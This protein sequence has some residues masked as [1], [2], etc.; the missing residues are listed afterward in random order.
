MVTK[1]ITPILEACSIVTQSPVIITETIE[2]YPIKAQIW[3]NWF[4]FAYLAFLDVARKQNVTSFAAI[5][6][7]NG[8]DAIGAIHIFGKSL[9]TIVLADINQAALEVSEKNL[10]SYSSGKRV[11]ALNGSLCRPLIG[12][13]ITVDLIYENLPNI[14][15]WENITTGYKQ[16]S[17]YSPK[18]FPV[19]A[20][21]KFRDY[22]LESHYSFLE[23][24]KSA[25]NLSGSAICS[26]GGRVPNNLLKEMVERLGYKYEELIAGFKRQTEP[27]E[28]LPG[29]AK[30]EKDGIEFEFYRYDDAVRRLESLG[31]KQPF[32]GLEGDKLKELLTPYRISAKE[33][34]R[35]YEQNSNYA[36]GHTIHMIRAIKPI[37]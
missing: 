13:G 10:G 32:V 23:E 18:S 17:V 5:G 31:I 35:L 21:K 25:L 16:A 9:E 29:Y 22:L 6:T 15:D 8:A 14:P 37:T 12:A 1:N 19:V 2:T 7:G 33:A 4:P 30:A 3:D 34:L 11:V 28:V 26:I 36:I 27:W 24:A 20:D